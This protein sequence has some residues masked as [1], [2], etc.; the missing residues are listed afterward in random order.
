MQE[1]GGSIPPSSTIKIKELSPSRAP[2]LDPSL[3]VHPKIHLNR[4]P[5]EAPVD[6]GGWWSL[7]AIEVR[8]GAA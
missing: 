5:L 2:D 1:V 7:L 8:Y 6:Y 3:E 4:K